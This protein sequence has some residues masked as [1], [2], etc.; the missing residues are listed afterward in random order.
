MTRAALVMA[1]A[2][3]AL[4][5]CSVACRGHVINVVAVLVMCGVV[6]GRLIVVDIRVAPPLILVFTL[7]NGD[8]VGHDRWSFELVPVV[9]LRVRLGCMLRV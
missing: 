4:G 7:V 9:R 5:G 8:R 2:V 3:L 1:L 6:T